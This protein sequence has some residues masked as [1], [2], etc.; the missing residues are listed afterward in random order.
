MRKVVNASSNTPTDEK[1]DFMNGFLS[2]KR[3]HKTVINQWRDLSGPNYQGRKQWG[4]KATV[5]QITAL[6]GRETI[7][8]RKQG[9]CKL[10]KSDRVLFYAVARSFVQ[11][12]NWNTCIRREVGTKATTWRF[13]NHKSEQT[14]NRRTLTLWA[15]QRYRTFVS[16]RSTKVD[17]IC[18]N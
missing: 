3:F 2:W 12:F 14:Q 11:L 15:S 6:F 16:F 4:K 9:L 10:K 8:I 1:K 18:T 7:T 13:T 5:T 17:M